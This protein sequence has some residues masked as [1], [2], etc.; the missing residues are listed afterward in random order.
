MK[1]VVVTAE[2]K[3]NYHFNYFNEQQAK[4]LV[5]LV[6]DLDNIQGSSLVK[7]V[8]GLE[9]LDEVNLLVIE[10]GDITEWTKTVGFYANSKG[11]PVVLSEMAYNSSE[12]ASFDIPKLDGISAVSP[13]GS[14]NYH[15]YLDDDVVDIFVTGH[16][17][18][19]VLP[20]YSPIEGRIL[21]LS[22]EH[23][24]DGG[25]GLRD[26]V[27]SLEASGYSV[28]VRVHPRENVS[29]WNGF[30][31]TDESSLLKDIAKSS[32]V[33]GVP[34]TGFTAALALGVPTIAVEGSAEKG[35]LPEYRYIFKYVKAKDIKDYVG[36]IDPVDEK[37]R[38]FITGPVGGAGDRLVD[39]GFLK[40]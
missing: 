30:R 29:L 7:T 26:A 37:S 31:L 5:H 17:M 20:P 19:D 15:G 8:T 39:F 13:Y 6:P 35:T 11:I 16:P 10:G 27:R 24:A 2:P 9:Q 21:V 38:H 23:K 3:A 33:V 28:E 14:F 25:A 32:V 34:G 18:L 40:L 4:H 36:N 22:S 12:P 1:I